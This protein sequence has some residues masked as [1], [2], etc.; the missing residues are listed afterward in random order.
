[1][2]RAS[3]GA[4]MHDHQL[5][6]SAAR[7]LPQWLPSSA[8]ATMAAQRRG[9][10]HVREGNDPSRRMDLWRGGSPVRGILGWILSV[11]QARRVGRGDAPHVSQ[12]AAAG[13][14]RPVLASVRIAPRRYHGRPQRPSG[15]VHAYAGWV[16]DGL[17]SRLCAIPRRWPSAA[18][19]SHNHEAH[20]GCGAAQPMPGQ[21]RLRTHTRER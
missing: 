6:C 17:A 16:H 8:L 7:V 10:P 21:A 15:V 19:G 12:R 11:V 1:M 20:A 18:R 5:D 2:P 3:P 4:G 14:R 9:V 13:H